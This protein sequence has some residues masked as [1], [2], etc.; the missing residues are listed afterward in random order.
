[1]T[2]TTRN[3]SA[4]ILLYR[5]RGS[6][7]EVLLVH[8][9]GP[10]WTNK[11]LAA[12]SIPKDLCEPDEDLLQTARR[13]FEEETGFAVEGNFLSLGNLKQPGVKIIHAWALEGELDADKIKSNT[14]TLEWPSN[15]GQIQEYPEVDKGA[16]YDLETARLKIFKGQHPFLDRLTKKLPPHFSISNEER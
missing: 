3:I 13:E 6:N 7:L 11:D 12:W 8:H 1:L 4:G 16:W 5:H 2:K 14:F 9:G 15:S 10:Y